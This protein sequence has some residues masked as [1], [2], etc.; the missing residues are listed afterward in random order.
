MSC[1]SKSISFFPKFIYG[2]I[3]I[4][5]SFTVNANDTTKLLHEIEKDIALMQSNSPK[6]ENLHDI[7]CVKERINYCYKLDQHVRNKSIKMLNN[8]KFSQLIEKIDL[9]NTNE[10]KEIL[11]LH[12]WTI[13]SKFGAETDRQAWLLVQHA[14]QDL[15]FQAG[16]AFL[17]EKLVSLGETDPKNFAYLYDRVT[18]NFQD[19]GLKQKYGTQADLKENTILIKPFEGTLEELNLRRKK[20]GL[21]S[22]D[23]YQKQ[24]HEMYK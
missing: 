20:I 3:I 1:Q 4:I 7:H 10:I 2:F 13:I 24:L 8:I 23:E 17:L 22:M 19:L 12:G 9:F 21:N 14:D 15:F 18:V 6:C 16:I 5:F 11:K